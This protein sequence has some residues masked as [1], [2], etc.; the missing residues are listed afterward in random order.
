MFFSSHVKYTNA[1]PHVVCISAL[2]DVTRR[3]AV[4]ACTLHAVITYKLEEPLY[5]VWACWRHF[6]GIGLS[7]C[8]RVYSFHI[9]IG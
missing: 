7:I 2:L 5:W 9:K 8:T 1:G 3:A 6:E 4:L